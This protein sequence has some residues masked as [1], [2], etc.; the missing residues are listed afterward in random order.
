MRSAQRICRMVFVTLVFFGCRTDPVAPQAPPSA[1]DAV[2]T[3]ADLSLRADRCPNGP[4]PIVR[5][6]E[7]VRESVNGLN[8]DRYFIEVANRQAYPV[9]LFASSPNLPPCGLNPMA[10]R[11]WV[12]V[13]GLADGAVIYTQG[14]CD[15]RDPAN[16]TGIWFAVPVGSPA[17]THAQVVM[18]DRACGTTYRSVPT[19][20]SSE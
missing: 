14:F 13:Q 6:L 4:P 18:E 11:T 16:L 8:I 15:L 2:A 19:R 1:E 3:P 9:A 17:V 10:S 12:T 5:L 7:V 20:I